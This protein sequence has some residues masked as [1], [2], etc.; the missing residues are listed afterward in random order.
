MSIRNIQ[1][2]FLKNIRFFHKIKLI[3]Y[4]GVKNPRTH[5]AIL[6][7]L[8]CWVWGDWS[9][10]LHFPWS[11]FIWAQFIRARSFVSL[12]TRYTINVMGGQPHILY[13]KSGIQRPLFSPPAN[14]KQKI[15][16]IVKQ[17]LKFSIPNWEYRW[18]I[19]VSVDLRLSR[20]SAI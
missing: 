15:R 11:F 14:Y 6:Y 1:P 16:E 12:Q 4:P 20:I 5:L 7:T 3:L 9:K 8:P 18:A 13:Q 19:P 2:L 10:N 17:S